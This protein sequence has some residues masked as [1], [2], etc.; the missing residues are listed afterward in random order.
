MR[1]SLAIPSLYILTTIIHSALALQALLSS[2]C[3]VQCGNVLESTSGNDIVC[4]DSGYTSS[5]GT[6]YQS[7][8]SCQLSS[9]YVDPSTKQTDLQWALYNLRYAISWCLWGYPN[10]TDV[11]DTPCIT[12]T[13]CA[14]LQGAIEFDSLSSNASEYGY[15]ALLNTISVPKCL[16]CLS[17]QSADFYLTNFLTALEAA[18]NQQPPSGSTISI[19]GSLFSTTTMNITSPSLS[20][21]S[22]Y[23]PSSGGLSLGAKIGIIVAGILVILGIAG[24]CIVWRGRRRRQRFLAKHQQESGY[25]DWLAARHTSPPMTNGEFYDSP[26]SQRPL[27]STHPWGKR[28]DESPASAMGEKHFSPYSSHY[29]SPVSAHDHIQG[30]TAAQDLPLDRKGSLGGRKEK[31]TESETF[32]MQAVAPVLMHPGNGRGGRG[33]GE[34]DARSGRAL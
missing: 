33:M 17:V 16:A 10:N 9:T 32:E 19:Q 24:F 25:T 13:A 7:C 26:Q 6:I 21:G 18:C 31:E 29:S 20:A 30:G 11:G 3:A 28:E 15:C 1:P 12:S 8:L 23:T 5:A 4:Q 27:N 34:E 14:P 22:T 2:P